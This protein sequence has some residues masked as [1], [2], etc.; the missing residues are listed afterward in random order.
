MAA[1]PVWH[2][3]RITT[4]YTYSTYPVRTTLRRW[5]LSDA[6]YCLRTPE[7]VVI[8]ERLD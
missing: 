5:P 8:A 6:H 2:T 3:Y 7:Y 1:S 4:Y